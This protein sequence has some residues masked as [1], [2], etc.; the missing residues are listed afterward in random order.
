MPS[1]NRIIVFQNNNLVYSSRNFVSIQLSY[2]SVP[3]GK[4]KQLRTRSSRIVTRVH[5]RNLFIASVLHIKVRLAAV[6]SDDGM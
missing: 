1:I 6:H 3:A 4:H 5:N 2:N